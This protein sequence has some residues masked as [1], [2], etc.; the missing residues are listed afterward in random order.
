MPTM[1]A[2]VYD[3]LK[4][5][6][7]IE[8]VGV[9]LAQFAES[10]SPGGEFKLEGKSWVYRPLNF[11]TFQVQRR[12]PTIVIAFSGHPAMF[13]DR[14]EKADLTLEWRS[15]SN[16]MREYSMYKIANPGQLLAA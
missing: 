9:A 5:A 2:T 7:E 3:E 14:A 12:S 6:G 11:V 10:L 15:L 4:R 8:C 16:I 1:S 13:K